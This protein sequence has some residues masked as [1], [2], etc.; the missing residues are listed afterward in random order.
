MDLIKIDQINLS[1]DRH[2]ID[3]AISAG[4]NQYPLYFQTQDACLEPNLEAFLALALLAGMKL[5]AGIAIP[6]GDLSKR[7]LAGVERIQGV[8]RGWKPNYSHVDLVNV[9]ARPMTRDQS[10]EKGVFFSAGLD[11]YYSFLTHLDEISSFVY[12]DGFDIPLSEESMRTRAIANCREIGR[13]FKKRAIIVETNARDFVEKHVSWSYSHG[14]VM[15]VVGL[16]LMP[17]F[18]RFYVAGAGNPADRE[19]FGSHPDLDP[20]WSTEI[21]EFIHE[22][23]VDKIDKC[24]LISNYDFAL[25]TIHVCLRYPDTGLNC[26]QCEKCLRTQVYLESV[27]AGERTTAFPGTLD[28]KSLGNLKVSYDPQLN[29]LY[30]ALRMLEAQSENSDTVSVLR[31]ILYRPTWQ[32]KLLLNLRKIRKKAVKRLK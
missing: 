23:E 12:L 2:R 30:K 10:G 18:E 8:F 11:S 4:R 13:Y 24:R 29:L 6:E 21:L 20:N 25:K 5:G 31:K 15:G 14:S 3:L 26:G 28:L 1:Q 17:Q 32:N 7:F 9:P 19:P 22:A 16:L 27:G